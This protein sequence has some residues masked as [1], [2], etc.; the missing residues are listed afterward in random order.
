MAAG[1]AEAGDVAPAAAEEGAAAVET[2]RY[3]QMGPPRPRTCSSAVRRRNCARTLRGYRARYVLRRR[4]R[5]LP[6]RYMLGAP[7]WGAARRASHQRRSSQHY[8]GTRRRCLRLHDYSLLKVTDVFWHKPLGSLTREE[9]QPGRWEEGAAEEMS[10]RRII[11]TG[12][13]KRAVVVIYSLC[14]GAATASN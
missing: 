12:N 4:I 3:P 13:A 8:T 9:E 5:A 1:A 6:A 11:S 14:S 2:S 10:M 7:R